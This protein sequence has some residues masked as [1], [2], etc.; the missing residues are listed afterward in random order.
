[1]EDM[2][3][4]ALTSGVLEE[5]DEQDCCGRDRE[6]VVQMQDRLT[7]IANVLVPLGISAEHVAQV[8]CTGDIPRGEVNVIKGIAEPNSKARS[9]VELSYRPGMQY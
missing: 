4:Q 3:A 5:T 8:S 1:M 7:P 2:S 6:S 9:R